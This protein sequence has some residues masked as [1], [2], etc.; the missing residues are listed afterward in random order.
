MFNSKT[1]FMDINASS[2][3]EAM[4]PVLNKKALYSDTTADYVSPLEPTAYGRVTIRF[5]TAKNNADHVI[6]VEKQK[7]HNMEKE[8]SDDLFDYYFHE[9]QLDNMKISYYFEVHSGKMV[10]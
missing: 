2:Y 7:C 1:P 4:R 8:Y 3:I 5:R 9:I 10:H 6:I